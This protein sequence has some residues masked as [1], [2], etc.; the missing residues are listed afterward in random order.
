M[1]SDKRYIKTDSLFPYFSPEL[2][3]HSVT[4]ADTET[5]CA[6]MSV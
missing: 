4:D 2:P 5:P 6:I 3:V 1:T